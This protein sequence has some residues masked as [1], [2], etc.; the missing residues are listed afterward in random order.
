M[1]SDQPAGAAAEN[2]HAALAPAPA[3]PGPDDGALGKT[4]SVRRD[5]VG[6][7]LTCMQCMDNQ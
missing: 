2:G 3:L 4:R 6:T 1:Q 7:H 5:S